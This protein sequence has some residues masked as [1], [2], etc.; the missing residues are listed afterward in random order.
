MKCPGKVNEHR[1]RC[2]VT[3]DGSPI[4]EKVDHLM[5]S[6]VNHVNNINNTNTNDRLAAIENKLRS[7]EQKADVTY[8]QTKNTLPIF[9]VCKVGIWFPFQFPKI[10]NCR[11]SCF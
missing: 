9:Q 11:I 7:M 6:G 3:M 5:S 10:L 8:N 1:L 2:K 4:E